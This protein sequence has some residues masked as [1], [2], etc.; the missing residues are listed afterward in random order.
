MPSSVRR[1]ECGAGCPLMYAGPD[2]GYVH[3]AGSTCTD[4]KRKSV[5]V[6]VEEL[7]RRAARAEDFRRWKTNQTREE[8]VT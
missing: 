3:L 2:I 4:Q 7:H 8:I 6:P 1:I 5:E